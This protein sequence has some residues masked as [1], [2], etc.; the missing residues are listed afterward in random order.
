[1]CHHCLNHPNLTY[2]LM[3]TQTKGLTLRHWRKGLEHFATIRDF[4]HAPSAEL[5]SLGLFEEQIH[6]IQHPDHAAI[7][8][9]L[10]WG[11]A[12]HCHF[13]TWED[14]DYPPLLRQ[15]ANPPYVLYVTGTKK[16]LSHAQ[17]AMVGSRNP[18]LSGEKTAS[19]FAYALASTGLA[20]T[21]GLALGID[22]ASHRGALQAKGIT[23]AI[24]G[25]GLRHIYPNRHRQLAEEIIAAQGALVSEFSLNTRPIAKNFPQRNRIISGLSL[26]VLIVEAALQSGSLITAS[27]AVEQNREVFAIPGSIHHPLARGCHALIRQGAKL[28]ETAQDVLEELGSLYTASLATPLISPLLKPPTFLKF[29]GYAATAMDTI[30]EQSG[31]TAAEVSSILLE[32]ELAGQVQKVVGGYMR[33]V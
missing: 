29:I 12:E 17:I 21:S 24:C 2:W 32:L 22:A 7:E 33:T 3:T 13:M 20:I 19:Q 18:S 16:A 1:M 23:I 5:Q 25:T 11:E 15:I 9:E 14:P 31:L 8:Q 30:I 26:G 10:R 27:C 6:A 4:I 28:V